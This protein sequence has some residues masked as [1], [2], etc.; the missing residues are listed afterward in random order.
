MKR[1]SDRSSVAPQS[2]LNR[3]T[4]PESLRRRVVIA[5]VQPSVDGGRFPIKRT[6]GERVEVTTVIIAD[7]HDLLTGTLK[8][9]DAASEDATTTGPT[10]TLELEPRF[11]CT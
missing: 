2:E 10:L 8:Y 3:N 6:V 4:L 5:E 11:P 1:P 7:G 9:R